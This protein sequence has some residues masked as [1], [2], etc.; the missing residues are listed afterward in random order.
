MIA[1]QQIAELRRILND[2][3]AGGGRIA[4]VPTMG[5]LHEGHLSLCD[6]GRQ[7][8]DFLVMSV[9]VNPLQFGAG[10]DLDRYPRDLTR[11]AGLAAGRGVN[12]IFAPDVPEMYPDGPSGVRISAPAMSDRLCG[13]FRPGH[14]EGVLTVV[15]KL[16]NIVMPDV[17]VFG[18]KD[19][20]QAAL[21][22]RMV[23]DLD[24]PV[25]IRVAPLI[26]EPDGLAMSSRNVFL[27]EAERAAALSLNLSLQAAQ[28]LFGMGESE[29]AALRAAAQA[30]LD[31]QPG[32]LVEYL[33]LVDPGTLQTPVRADRGHALAVAARVGGTRLIDNHL[34]D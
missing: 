9:F 7:H 21:V 15:A 14:F 12:L 24:F 17:A 33:E 25:R 8:A 10:E 5:Y 13:R 28:A 3:R 1:T 34:L 20:Q 16:F 18:Q 4:L 31:G 32:V 11:D 2:V 6:V 26:R 22:R 19:L 23:A 29:P 30:I 27:S